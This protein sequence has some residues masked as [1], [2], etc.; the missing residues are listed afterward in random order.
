MLKMYAH[1]L[2]L[3]NNVGVNIL[4]VGLEWKS[5]AC[6]K[7][8]ELGENNRQ[9]QKTYWAMHSEYLYHILNFSDRALQE[10]NGETTGLDKLIT[11]KQLTFLLNLTF[12]AD[13]PLRKM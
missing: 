13:S 12:T 8:L 6:L 7:E 3:I 4:E 11:I 5:Q 10:I 1:S 9:N 2:A